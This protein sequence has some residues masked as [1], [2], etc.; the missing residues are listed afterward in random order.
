MFKICTFFSSLRG[1]R[2][3]HTMLGM[4][5]LRLK[6]SRNDERKSINRIIALF[7]FITL[8]LFANISKAQLLDSLSLDTVTAYTNLQEALKNPDA[9]IKLVLRK[10]HFK[11]FPQEILNFKNLQYLDLSKNSIKE[12]PDSIGS[13]TNLQYFVCSKTGLERIPKQIGMLTNLTYINFNQNELVALPPQIG[14]LD[15]LKILDL[16][17]NELDTF[18]ETLANLSSLQV[19]DLRN[20]LLGDDVQKHLKELMPKAIVHLSPSCK[21]KW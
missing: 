17:S 15:K 10:Q 8:L 14:N 4:R 5:L 3:S 12:L 9:V 11:S 20:I 2:Q 19:M 13:L 1:T 7:S 6:K 21:C 16:W 18:P